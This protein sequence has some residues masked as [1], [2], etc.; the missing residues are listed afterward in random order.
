METKQ[1]LILN[2]AQLILGSRANGFGNRDVIWVQ[3]C[4]IKCKGCNNQHMWSYEKKHLIPVSKLATKVINRTGEIE[5]ITISGG[6][7]I[8]QA[9]AVSQLLKT[10]KEKGLNTIVYSGFTYKKLID[11]NDFWI[12]ELLKYTDILIDGKFEQTQYN[13]NQK[14]YGSDNQKIIVLNDKY[15]YRI[16]EDVIHLETLIEVKNNIN[17]YVNESGIFDERK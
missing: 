3:G 9:Q 15:K 16:N 1:E 4:S 12:N 2:V 14:L 5:G 13:D 7:P 6:E 10:I 17:Y 11:L 8:E